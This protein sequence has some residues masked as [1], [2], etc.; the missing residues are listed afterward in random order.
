MSSNKFPNIRRRICSL[1]V[2]VSFSAVSAY[3]F[4]TRTGTVVITSPSFAMSFR[5]DNHTIE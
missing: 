1:N 4:Y 2:N 3:Q 5:Q